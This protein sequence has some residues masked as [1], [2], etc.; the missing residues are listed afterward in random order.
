MRRRHV[1]ESRLYGIGL[2]IRL[3]V[4]WVWAHEGAHL[5]PAKMVLQSIEGRAPEL[6]LTD[7]AG[8]PLSLKELRGKVVLLTFT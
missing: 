3:S 7:Q 1:P 2:L 6:A 5:A 8:Q 4:S